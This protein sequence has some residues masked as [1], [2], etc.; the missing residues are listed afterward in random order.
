M[1]NPANSSSVLGSKQHQTSLSWLCCTCGGITKMVLLINQTATRRLFRWRLVH[2]V[3]NTGTDLDWS[4]FCSSLDLLIREETWL[5]NPPLHFCRN[6]PLAAKIKCVVLI[7]KQV[8]EVMEAHT[9]PSC[10]IEHP[11]RQ[12]WKTNTFF[13]VWGFESEFF[14]FS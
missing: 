2:T 7:W 13:D 8:V 10:M 1:W 4:P 3:C 5:Q 14:F 6:V 12:L 9:K 11:F